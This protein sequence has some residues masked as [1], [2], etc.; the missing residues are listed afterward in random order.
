M[1]KTITVGLVLCALLNLAIFSVPA[2]ACLGP[3]GKPIEGT[4]GA[5]TNCAGVA[6]TEEPEIDPFI[7]NVDKI[8]FGYFS[9]VGRTYTQTFV[10][11]NNSDQTVAVKLSAD[12]PVDEGLADENKLGAEWITFVGGVKYFEIAP[13]SNKTVGVRAVIPA[14]A[15]VGSQ[16]AVITVENTTLKETHEIKVSMAVATEGLTFGGKIAK[17]DVAPFSLN[18]KIHA[19]ATI[20]NDGNA[21]FEAKYS[22]RAVAKFGSNLTEWTDIVKDQTAIV[23]PNSERTFKVEDD[24][25]TLGYGLFTVEQKVVYVNDKGEQIEEVSTRTVLNIPMWVLFVIGGVILLAV[26]V[27]VIVKV[28]KKKK[29]SDDE[30]DFGDEAEEEQPKKSRKAEKKAAKAEKKAAKAE[31]KAEKKSAKNDKKAEKKSEKKS[32]KAEDEE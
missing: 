28:V 5:V 25:A 7:V 19:S 4:D 12:K 2:S 18:D 13:K 17:S 20:K 31:K 1:K 29:G 9:E 30:E 16:Y 15:K 10:I 24:A 22:V 27:T 8:E 3:D 26:I 21:G 32:E 6:A 11:E 23:Y 14:D